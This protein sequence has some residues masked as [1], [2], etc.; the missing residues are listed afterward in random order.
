MTWPSETLEFAS[1]CGKA[2]GVLLLV[3]AAIVRIRKRFAGRR[4][5]PVWLILG[6]LSAPM[7]WVAVFPLSNRDNPFPWFFL[8][9]LM[10]GGGFAIALLAGAFLENRRKRD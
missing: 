2:S 9:F 7:A 1:N 8:F 4:R 3:I 6:A 5:D 10:Y